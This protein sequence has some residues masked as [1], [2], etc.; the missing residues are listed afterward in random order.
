MIILYINNV[1]SVPVK[2]TNDHNIEVS[3][4]DNNKISETINNRVNDI[5][6]KYK[7]GVDDEVQFLDNP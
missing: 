7:N 3:S 4:I 1:F 6:E 2:K 5:I